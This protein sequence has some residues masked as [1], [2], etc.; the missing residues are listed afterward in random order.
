MNVIMAW[1]EMLWLSCSSKKIWFHPFMGIDALLRTQS[2]ANDLSLDKQHK[3]QFRMKVAQS[4]LPSAQ[5]RVSGVLRRKLH[6]M[7]RLIN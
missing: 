3:F 5:N 4:T 7:I 6:R 2:K 1:T